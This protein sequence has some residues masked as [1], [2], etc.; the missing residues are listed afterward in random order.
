MW[1]RTVVQ[2][3]RTNISVVTKTYDLLSRGLYIHATSTLMNSGTQALQLVSCF[4]QTVDPK[5]TD[6]V[7]DGLQKTASIFMN[8]GGVSLD[9]HHVP[10]KRLIMVTIFSPFAGIL[11]CTRADCCPSQPGILPLMQIIDATTKYITGS[12]HSRASAATVFI[13]PWHTDIFQFVEAHA[14]AGL[15]DLRT[16]NIF[17][18]LMIPDLLYVHAYNH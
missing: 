17:T 14:N 1:M 5:S 6:T 7:F 9:L 3:H 11:P 18:A 10:L 12:Q 13:P 2:L 4:L 8:N 15:E 16:Q